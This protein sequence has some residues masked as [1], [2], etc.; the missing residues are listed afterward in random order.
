[1]AAL[2]QLLNPGGLVDQVFAYS[3]AA[4][5]KLTGDL[6]HEGSGNFQANYLYTDLKT[7]GLI[8]STFGPKIK[9][10]PFLEDASAIHASIQKFV[11]SFVDSF[12]TDSSAFEQD[13]ELQAWIA[14]A[15]P[16]QIM[17]FPTKADR[18][19]LIDILTHVAFLG[20]AEHQTL[21]TN[22]ISEA[23]GS[24]PF[25]PFALYQPIPTEKGVNDIVPFLPNIT[26]SVGQIGLTA[27]FARATFIDSSVSLTQMFND[28]VMLA[29]MNTQTTEAAA[30]FQNEMLAFSGVVSSRTFDGDRLCQG[31]P[32]IWK[33]LDPQRAPYYLT[34]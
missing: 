4:G 7:R 28:S 15:V 2:A 29:R 6:Y 17:D 1:V 25:H 8:N 16:A 12:Y 11:T 32:F 3:G 26:Q 10:F 5:T 24:L 19:T 21:N 18:N 30:T 20:S 13:T 34:I 23:S 33:A 14:E 27:V 9:H 31:M 22:D